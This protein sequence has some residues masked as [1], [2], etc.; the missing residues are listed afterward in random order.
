MGNNNNNPY[1]VESRGYDVLTPESK[2]FRENTSGLL[3]LVVTDADIAYRCIDSY[4]KDHIERRKI[5]P[6]GTETTENI[7]Y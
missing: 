3:S 4:H 7:Y 5:F 1:Q 6:N 2:Q